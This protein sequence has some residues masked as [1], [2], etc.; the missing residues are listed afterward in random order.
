MM[1]KNAELGEMKK[2]HNYTRKVYESEII[3]TMS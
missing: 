3:G 1:Q 2:P